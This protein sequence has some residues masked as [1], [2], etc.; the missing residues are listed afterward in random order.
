MIKLERNPIMI[1]YSCKECGV[2][3]FSTEILVKEKCPY[4]KL[5]LEVDEIEE[6]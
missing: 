3:K 2:S 1:E 5:Y 6:E 4:C